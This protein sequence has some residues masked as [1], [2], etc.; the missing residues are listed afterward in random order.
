MLSSHFKIKIVQLLTFLVLVGGLNWGSIGCFKFDFVSSLSLWIDLKSGLT[1]QGK[2]AHVAQVVFILVGMAALILF[3]RRSTWLPFLGQTIVPASLIPVSTNLSGNTTIE[4]DVKPK[5]K[6]MYWASKPAT[7]NKP[8]DVR[9]AYDNYSNSGVVLSDINGK[10]HLV[11][12]AGNGYTINGS[13]IPP[14]IHYR[15][16]NEQDAMI[17]P[18]KTFYL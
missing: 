9:K 4:I 10:A 5:T 7:T 1:A 15:E 17:G 3:F 6:I 14:H 13:F 18:I 2:T 16:L 12:N 11:F 8:D